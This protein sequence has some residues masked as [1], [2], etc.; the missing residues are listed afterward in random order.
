MTTKREPF[1]WEAL[2]SLLALIISIGLAIVK[3]NTA[4]HVPMLLGAFVAAVMAYRAG[5]N[6]QEIE[7]GMMDGISQ[8]LQAVIILSIIGVLV[9]VW[10]LSGVVPTMIYYGLKILS[11]K[12]FLVATVLICSITSLATGSSWGTAGTVG[13]A[14]IGVGKGLGMPMPLVAGAILSGAYFGDKMS[15]LS[16]TT[17]L[18]PAM[19][20]TDL[21]IHIRHMVYTTGV[22][23]GIVLIVETILG[24]MY[25]DGN[26]QTM[27]RVNQIMEGLSNQFNIS[28]LLLIPP[29][30]V[31][32]LAAKKIPAIPGIS[33]GI[34]V[35]A[36]L[37][38][39]LQSN[40]FREILISAY[41]GYVSNT[42]VEALDNL[43]TNGGFT[44]MLY[45][46]SIVITAMMF[47]G[48]MENTKQLKVI[49]FKI[50]QKAQSDGLL[51]AATL[52]TAIG[53]NVVLSEQYMSIV[54]TG[55]MYAKVYRDRGLH[56]KNLSRA[57]ED[58]GTLTGALVPWNT[59]GAYMSSTLGVAT[60]AYAPFAFFLWL[61]P[62]VSMI[63]GFWG[64]TID[65]IEDEVEK[66]PKIE[67]ERK[68][69]FKLT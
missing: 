64:I 49:V 2:I 36:V 17:N 9:G 48:I 20:G 34:I 23:Y 56:A 15:P 40:N 59:C 12:I 62:I 68:N 18:A 11:P 29:I 55:R 7:E 10:I 3:Y 53:M 57:L 35:G 32:T 45:S 8:A 63:F 41:D 50:L 44:N 19:A 51:I 24:F 4:P 27:D 22:S 1:F 16:D 54:V 61:T 21:F 52:L 69:N 66:N 43:L 26:L 46:I 38:F 31:I 47:G 67:E 25:V 14:L 39:F 58:S 33:I 30:I 28:L 6:W 13:V 60:V 5:Y 65:S 37:G 42:G